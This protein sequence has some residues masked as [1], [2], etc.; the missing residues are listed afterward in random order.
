M[1]SIRDLYMSGLLVYAVAALAGFAFYSR[2]ITADWM[3]RWLC[4]ASLAAAAFEFAASVAALL[5]GAEFNWS[6]PSGVPFLHYGVRLDPLSA[7]FNLALSL[8]AACVAIYSVGYLKHSA[9]AAVPASSVA[10]S[11]CCCWLLTLVF[12]AAN[13][14][15]FLVAWE[16]VVVTS[17][18]L[19][20]HRP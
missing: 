12:T 8:L 19:V 15:F 6:L 17:Y 4:Y 18:F 5:S 16:L 7:F 1:E 20:D 13:V 9:A 2:K 10:S 3:V 11:I 14:L